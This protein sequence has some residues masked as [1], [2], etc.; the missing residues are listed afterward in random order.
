MY[1]EEIAMELLLKTDEFISKAKKLLLKA[2]DESE[3]DTT[4]DI[5]AG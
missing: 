2:D 4:D 1:N 5:L 3:C